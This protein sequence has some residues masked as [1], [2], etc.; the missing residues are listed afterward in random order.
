MKAIILLL[1][2]FNLYAQ[3]LADCKFAF[4]KLG[5]GSG[6]DQVS[7]QCKEL[8][9]SNSAS[10]AKDSYSDETIDREYTGFQNA[11]LTYDK[12]A[13]ARY[14]TAGSNTLLEDVGAVFYDHA[15]KELYVIDTKSSRLL[16]FLSEVPGNVAPIRILEKDELVGANDVAVIGDS[17]YILNNTTNK[18][19]VYSRLASVKAREDKQFLDLVQS[20]DI[21]LEAKSLEVEGSD[22]ILKDQDQKK[23]STLSLE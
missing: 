2:S 21:S 10:N 7:A 4:S 12:K 22:L 1:L 9:S 17:L 20:V 19:L 3:N 23:L 18:L 11:L 5:D 6:F 14:L 15:H 16:V 8:I 13:D